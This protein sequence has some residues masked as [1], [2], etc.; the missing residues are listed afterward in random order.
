M[1]IILNMC[2]CITFIFKI[3]KHLQFAITNSKECNHY[4]LGIETKN[5]SRFY[6]K[7]Y[8]QNN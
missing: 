3:I 5:A 2:Y 6:T 8:L 7:T 4:S 1:R